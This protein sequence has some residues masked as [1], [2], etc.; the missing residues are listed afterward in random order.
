M[1]DYLQVR[2][3]KVAY[4]SRSEAAKDADFILKSSRLGKGARKVDKDAKK[5]RPYECER[6]GHWHITTAKHKKWVKK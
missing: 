2:C 5:L 1:P 6:C 4:P 3:S